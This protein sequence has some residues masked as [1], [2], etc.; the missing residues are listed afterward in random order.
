METH[1]EESPLVMLTYKHEVE[2]QN[3]WD[4]SIYSPLG[5][6]INNQFRWIGEFI[7]IL[8]GVLHQFFISQLLPHLLLTT[9]ECEKHCNLLR[10]A[11]YFQEL[12]NG[13]V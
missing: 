10:K 9:H 3:E 13:F 6:N 2:H 1:Q 11:S 12:V 7:P 5:S 4:Q 8:G